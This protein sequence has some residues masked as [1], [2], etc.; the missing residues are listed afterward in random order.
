MTPVGGTAVSNQPVFQWTG[1][2]GARRYGLQVDDDTTF[3]TADFLEDV[4]TTSTGYTS[5]ETYE[6]DTNMYWR[7]CPL[8]ERL[9]QLTCSAVASFNRKLPAPVPSPTNISVSD[10]LPTWAWAPWSARSAT[11]STSS[12]RTASARRSR[13][14]TPRPPIRSR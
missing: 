13:T 1:V 12:C 2:E 14:T 8:D 10:G 4:T 11:S 7:V 6:A 9:Q 5:Q 3:S